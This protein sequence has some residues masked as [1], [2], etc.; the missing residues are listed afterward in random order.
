MMQKKILLEKETAEETEPEQETCDTAVEQQTPG[1]DPCQKLVHLY[2]STPQ[3][4]EESYAIAR[5]VHCIR[6][7]VSD[8]ADSRRVQLP[9]RSGIS[10]SIRCAHRHAASVG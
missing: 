10:S 2:L 5:Q 8:C 7:D 1:L 9:N 6:V 3:E 4:T